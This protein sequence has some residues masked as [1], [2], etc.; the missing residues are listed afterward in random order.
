MYRRKDW[1]NPPDKSNLVLCNSH[2]SLVTIELLK[3]LNMPEYPVIARFR[4]KITRQ[5]LPKRPCLECEKVNNSQ[6]FHLL[7]I[8]AI[9]YMYYSGT[10]LQVTLVYQVMHLQ[11]ANIDHYGPNIRMKT[12][13]YGK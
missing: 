3:D 5:K 1:F 2:Y 8:V 13:P 12:T 6:L 11:V 7:Y 10:I 4:D 9:L